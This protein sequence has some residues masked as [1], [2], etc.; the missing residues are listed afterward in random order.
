MCTKYWTDL[1][2]SSK[3]VVERNRQAEEKIKELQSEAYRIKTSYRSFF[4]KAATVSTSQSTE[5][6]VVDDEVSEAH[7]EAQAADGDS[8]SDIDTCAKRGERVRIVSDNE[9][10]ADDP[11]TSSDRQRPKPRQEALK[12][13]ISVI[14]ADIVSLTTKRKAGLMEEGGEAKLKKLFQNL[15]QAE[16]QL[17]DKKA[18][19]L[20]SKKLRKKKKGQI[21]K[22]KV[23]YPDAA[24]L[25]TC[26]EEP[27]RPRLEEDQPD[28]LKVISDI[29][30]YSSSAADRRRSETLRLCGTLDE[31]HSELLERGFKISRSATYLRL[32][33][34]H[35]NTTEGKRHISTVPVKLC[36][37][38]SDHHRDHQDQH[39]CRATIR[40]MEEIASVLGPKQVCFISQDD[41][42]KVPIG[43]TAAK[44]QAPLLM[45]M[46]YRIQLPNHDFVI[47]KVAP[48]P[49]SPPP[50]AG[51][52]F[53]RPPLPPQN[54]PRGLCTAPKPVIMF[55][56]DGG[57]DENPRYKKVILHGIDHFKKYDLDALFIFTNAPGRSAFNRVERR[58]AHLSRALSGLILEYDHFGS[59]LDGNGANVDEELEL[60]NFE[61]AGTVLSDIW[62]EMVLDGH[63]VEASYV[64]PGEN[65]PNVDEVT[66]SWFADHCRESQYLF[67]VI[68][69]DKP[70][71]CQPR[72][73]NLHQLLYQRFLPAPYP[74]SQD[75]FGVSESTEIPS[76]PPFLLR[77]ALSLRPEYPQCKEVPYDFYCPSVQSE[78]KGRTCEDYGIYFCSKTS[79]QLHRREMH[80]RAQ[81]SAARVTPLRVLS[82]RPGELLCTVQGMDCSEWI[83]VE[84]VDC[85]ELESLDDISPVAPIITDRRTWMETGLLLMMITTLLLTMC[86]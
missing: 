17:K 60:K 81:V 20:R 48:N 6:L 44:V 12:R 4:S 79:L 77:Q 14:Q 54:R 32:I 25:L 34:R 50:V 22:I 40:S 71:C 58:M 52:G 85:P 31:L 68:K 28:L 80:P 2:K 41:K 7:A 27:G 42:A 23:H 55:S 33:P 66:E 73:S 59:H 38:Q 56:V 83:D 63:P 46:E 29:A 75:P 78:V 49:P 13:E 69:C 19:A 62:S 82:R 11:E 1:K 10:D 86:N 37:A 18:R 47:G 24:K 70:A 84:N 53:S 8:G 39:F 64:S 16:K 67:Q 43:L 76:F 9:D 35:W 51:R 26:R 74:F 57:P 30:I 15:K 45:H 72:R 5:T 65:L 36:R 61:Y 3:S 21:E